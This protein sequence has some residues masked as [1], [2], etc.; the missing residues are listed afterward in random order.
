MTFK[1]KLCKLFAINNQNRSWGSVI[2]V[3]FSVFSKTVTNLP[4]EAIIRALD[5]QCQ[6]LKNDLELGRVRPDEDTSSILHFGQFI[7]TI[8]N[9]K[10]I[11]GAR[12]LPPDHLEFYKE[13]MVR[14]IQANELPESAMQQFANAFPVS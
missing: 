14:L 7:E 3:V 1:S 6:M 11:S 2:V 12:Y 13:T 8:K 5:L 10:A 9:G 4:K